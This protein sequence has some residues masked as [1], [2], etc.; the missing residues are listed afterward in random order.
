M[1]LH[2]SNV[3]HEFGK[4]DRVY[5]AEAVSSVS[6]PVGM[7]DSTSSHVASQSSN[8]NRPSD[9][10]ES[11]G[12]M[13]ACIQ[14]CQNIFQLLAIGTHWCF[15]LLSLIIILSVLAT[16]PVVQF[17]SLGY[18][19]EAGGR[20]AR[21]GK[22]RRGFIGISDAAR[23]G[24]I[25]LGV[26]LTMLPIRL[27]SSYWYSSSLLN[28]DVPQTRTLRS[29]VLV[30]GTLA[31]FQIL[32]AIFRG[33]RLRHFAWPA[34]VRLWRRIRQ[35]GM[36]DEASHRL[37]EFTRSLRLH[38]Y[39]WLG[40]R[41]FVAASIW[42]FVPIS[43]LGAATAFD[44]P[45]IGGFVAFL[46][47]IGLSIVLVYLP[48]LQ[49]RLPLTNEFRSQFQ[50][51]EIRKSF[52]RAPVAYWFSLLMS[53]ALAVPLYILKAEL[54]PREAAWLPSLFFI[55]LMFPAR[56]AVG[57]AMGRAERRTELRHWFFRWTGWLGM[58]PVVL[59][60]ALI[61]YFTQFTSWYGAASLYEQHAFLVPVPFLGY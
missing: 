53:L 1:N 55:T 56:L 43:M 40:L 26:F 18:L 19:L 6:L 10:A 44:N 48:F 60:Y 5:L 2:E 41:G 38:H 11:R 37:L 15:G 16:I 59:I 23:V 42:L 30:L 24:S 7:M 27:L 58:I 35:G 12:W 39:F 45:E 4:E 9:G 47:G 50:L 36:Y 20:V 51:A 33:G 8:C 61:V 46:G 52:K 14:F 57:W 22:I 29:M 3:A 25:A 32:W 31:M 49:M 54:I 21:T 13:A 17:L 28:G 34:P